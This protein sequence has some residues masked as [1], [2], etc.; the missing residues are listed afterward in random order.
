MTLLLTRGCVSQ[1]RNLPDQLLSSVEAT[2]LCLSTAA[3]NVSQAWSVSQFQTR[4]P[5]SQFPPQLCSCL[6]GSS[7]GRL[8]LAHLFSPICFPQGLPSQGLV[9]SDLP[10][11]RGSWSQLS[12]SNLVARK[13][14]HCASRAALDAVLE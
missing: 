6:D 4:L 9:L 1:E 3:L 7:S 14:P 2:S 13:Q 5:A 12:R 8:C 10:P 11:A